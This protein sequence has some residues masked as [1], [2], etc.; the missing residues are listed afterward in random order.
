M[1]TSIEGAT[2]VALFV[3]LTKNMRPDELDLE[4]ATHKE[5]RHIHRTAGPDLLKSV[6][7]SRSDKLHKICATA[8][9]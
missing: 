1:N 9:C 2:L 4:N 5:A 7:S 8:K 3:S 6:F